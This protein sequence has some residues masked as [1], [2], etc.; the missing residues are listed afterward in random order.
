M[1]KTLG[2]TLASNVPGNRRLVISQRTRHLVDMITQLLV[3]ESA[4]IIQDYVILKVTDTP[5]NKDLIDRDK[6]HQWASSEELA[7]GFKSDAYHV[8]PGNE[9]I[10]IF[11][12]DNREN[13]RDAWLARWSS[14]QVNEMAR[15]Q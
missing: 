14:V 13:V 11:W 4:E 8:T 12:G 2:A 10:G 5:I 15:S 9:E 3:T 6:L 1:S 7:I